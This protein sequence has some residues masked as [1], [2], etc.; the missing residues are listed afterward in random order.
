MATIRLKLFSGS[1]YNP[2]SEI[3]ISY[4]DDVGIAM[5]ANTFNKKLGE[6]KE[7]SFTEHSKSGAKP[8]SII[9][10]NGVVSFDYT[11]K[12]D[13]TKQIHVIK[14]RINE[15]KT[16][17]EIDNEPIFLEYEDTHNLQGDY[18]TVEIGQHKKYIRVL[19][20]VDKSTGALSDVGFFVGDNPHLKLGTLTLN[21]EPYAHGILQQHGYI[22][23]TLFDVG[24]GVIV[25][26]VNPAY[27]H[28]NLVS[29][30]SFSADIL[31][32]LFT[33]GASIDAKRL[34]EEN[35]LLDND[36]AI[37]NKNTASIETVTQSITHSIA[38]S[39]VNLAL[40]IKDDGNLGLNVIPNLILNGLPTV[41]TILDSPYNGYKYVTI[42]GVMGV[43]PSVVGF[44]IASNKRAVISH[45]QLCEGLNGNLYPYPMVNGDF[46]G[47]NWQGSWHLSKTVPTVPSI[48]G[49]VYRPNNTLENNFTLNI[50]VKPLWDNTPLDTLDATIFDFQGTNGFFKLYYEGLTGYLK[51]QTTLYTETVNTT[52]LTANSWVMITII[53]D[54]ANST[55]KFFINGALVHT[56]SNPLD[57]LEFLGNAN[58]TLA[59]GGDFNG[60]LDGLALFNSVLL[61]VD[62]NTI[63][64]QDL[65]VKNLGESLSNGLP[66]FSSHLGGTIGNFT[67]AISDGGFYQTQ[68]YAKVLGV[69]GDAPSKTQIILNKQDTI[70]TERIE[71]GNVSSKKQ[72]NF[73]GT[74]YADFASLVDTTGAEAVNDSYATPTPIAGGGY[75]KNELKP[76]ENYSALFSIGGGGQIFEANGRTVPIATQRPKMLSGGFDV[77]FSFIYSEGTGDVYKDVYPLLSFGNEVSKRILN[78]GITNTQNTFVGNVWVNS[79]YGKVTISKDYM[80]GIVTPSLVLGLYTNNSVTSTA[81]GFVAIDTFLVL[82]QAKVITLTGFDAVGELL[83]VDDKNNV[84]LTDNSGVTIQTSNITNTNEPLFLTPNEHNY[85][86]FLFKQHEFQSTVDELKLRD[87]FILTVYTKP[88]YKH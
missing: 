81:S 78:E 21:C 63:Y 77:Y 11:I 83:V 20:L 66:C 70:T 41:P 7:Q 3:K 80:R 16:A 48:K 36:I 14:G 32:D 5:L 34:L 46:V 87:N 50:W 60:V 88:Q 2:K 10:N 82:K 64:N 44:E 76:N 52:L 35:S 27:G 51:Y 25:G 73:Y 39:Q 22:D 65:Q 85:L 43:S 61:D 45:L 29:N 69:V 40:L 9:A 58:S 42:E 18:K 12:A 37:T 53:K 56:S 28:S 86:A 71:Y 26:N 55:V 62:I 1:I 15:L 84:Y 8:T 6:V 68:N 17:L 47:H 30:P 23:G 24:D 74:F 19:S 31:F 57:A 59:V 33:V 54:I 4:D 67:G 13:S 38:G 75:L 72:F 49:V 79:K